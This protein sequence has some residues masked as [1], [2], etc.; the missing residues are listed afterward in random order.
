MFKSKSKKLTKMTQVFLEPTNTT[1][2]QYEALRAFFVDE[3]PGKEA[4]QKV[5]IHRRNLPCSGS[6]V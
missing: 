4:A 5:R 6:S 1:H 3:L 2:R